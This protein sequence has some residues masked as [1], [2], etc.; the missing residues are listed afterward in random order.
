MRIRVEPLRAHVR[1]RAD[2][3]VAGIQ[4]SLHDFANAEIGDF[5]LHFLIDQNIGGL[6]IAV[7]DFV[8]VQVFKAAEDLV[9]DFG[10]EGLGEDDAV[11][12]EGF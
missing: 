5:N 7:D 2:V 4:S 6:Q 11:F 9:A 1:A 3:G 8:G 12:E 10:E